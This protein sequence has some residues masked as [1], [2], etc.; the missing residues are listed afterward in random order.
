MTVAT[1][2]S[3]TPTYVG[4]GVTMVFAYGF[5]LFNTADMVVTQTNLAGVETILI[6][7]TH[8][9]LS[10]VN[11]PGG[12]DITLITPLPTGH[13]LTGKCVLELIQSTDIK[14]Q[15]FF[16]AEL[17]EDVFDR[18]TK[19]DQQQQEQILR[20]LS[21]L[22]TVQTALATVVSLYD[23]FD[24]RYLG[25]KSTPPTL[26][27]DGN[28]LLVGAIYWDSSSNKLKAWNGAVWVTGVDT[29]S[30]LVY[31]T[32]TNKTGVNLALGDV[33]AVDAANNSAVV[34]ADV[35]SSAMQFVIAQGTIAN[36]VTGQFAMFSAVSSVNVAGT[37]TRGHY[38]VKSATTKLAADSGIAAASA[39]GP[40]PGSFAIALS[41]GTG[42][43]AA[44]LFGATLSPALG[45]NG[46]GVRTVQAGG[47][48]S[49]GID[50]DI[51]M[52]Y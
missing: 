8:Y 51:T 3:I 24:D 16:Q 21:P 26:D 48:P 10:G 2:S 7:T 15:G 52:I 38:L 4:N 41:G 29:I 22:T 5:R 36:N 30:G 49:G 33:V 31:P 14:N 37:I 12:G 44:L 45:S 42:T 23:Q 9:T 27:N 39:G 47:S 46:Y 32:F 25:S 40:P 13:L 43:V 19:I 20:A 17:H 28:A 6:F 50:G 11:S 1:S 35:A 18:L 34:L